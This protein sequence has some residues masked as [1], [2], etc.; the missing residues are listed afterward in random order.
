MVWQCEGGVRCALPGHSRRILR[1]KAKTEVEEREMRRPSETRRA[2][3]KK[4]SVM[5][6]VF[7]ATEQDETLKCR[8][9][10]FPRNLTRHPALV[11]GA[12]P[13]LPKGGGR[14]GASENG[15]GKRAQVAQEAED[16]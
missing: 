14:R 5:H 2:M 1:R 3:R 13:I 4:V 10:L 16:V 15:G 6:V 9:S 8:A 12:L 11:V 7:G